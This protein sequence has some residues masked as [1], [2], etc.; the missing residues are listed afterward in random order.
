[1]MVAVV[2]VPVALKP[3]L[4]TPSRPELFTLL[5]LVLEALAEQPAKAQTVVFL[6][7]TQML[8]EAVPKLKALEAAEA[9]V[10]EPQMEETAVPAAALAATQQIPAAQEPLDKEIMAEIRLWVVL[11]AAVVAHQPLAQLAVLQEASAALVVP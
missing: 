2:A 4:V 9:V 7:G 11:R 1:M 3:E 6:V 10:L 5:Q 8:L